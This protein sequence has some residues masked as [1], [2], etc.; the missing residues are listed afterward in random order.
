MM[1]N[2]IIINQKVI[3][4]LYTLY[5][6]LNDRLEAFR[7]EAEAQLIPIILKDTEQ[8]LDMMI[9]LVRPKRILE[10]GT[11]VGYSACFFAESAGPDAQIVSLEYN[12]D[13]CLK[14]A[15]NIERMGYSEQIQ[16]IPGDARES[17]KRLQGQFDMVFIDA[18]KSH[19][20]EF[21]EGILKNCHPGT[22]IIGD[23]VLI[24]AKVCS[25][26]LDPKGKF[27]TNIRHM[28]EF[29][30][31]ITTTD[32]ATSSVFSAGDGISVSVLK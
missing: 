20:L 2:D 24:R 11:A 13:M 31:F 21:W 9:K 1:R 26:D 8:F 3:D 7:K 5:H 17:I 15:E 19:Y 28:R 14:A 16:I 4:Y 29:L 27:R 32:T 22:V 23:N 12:L 25:D 18:G 30:E 6:P 10:F